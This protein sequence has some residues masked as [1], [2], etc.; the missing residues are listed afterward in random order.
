[1]K[2]LELYIHIPFCVQKCFYCDFLSMPV[3][4]TVRRHYVRRLIEETEYKS[5]QYKGYEITSVFFG[6]GTPS[7]L[8]ETQIAEIMEALQ[9]NFSIQK[10]AEITIECNPGTLARQKIITYKES[11]INRISMGLQSA[12][13][14]ELKMLGRIHTY[15]EFLHNYD[16]VRKGGI[17][18]VNVDLM[19][20]LPGQT[21]SDWERTLKEILKLR[22]EHISAYSLIIEEGTPFYQTYEEDEQRREEGEEP[23]YLPN[24]ETEREMY[25]LTGALLEEKGYMQYEIS[26]YAKKG[27]ECQHN[28][29]YWTRKNYLGLG[30]GSASLVENVRF[31]NTSDLQEYLAGDFEEREREVLER[32]EQMEE[33]M[34][35]GL[36]M[37]KGVSRGDFKKAFGVEIEAVYGE[38]IKKMVSQ[39]LLQQQAGRI[40]LTEEGISVSNYVMSEFLLKI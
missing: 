33:F 30:L 1:M 23:K 11:G 27:R 13:N 20:A 5:Q 16:L 29:G 6:G 34:F 3:D 7:I 14:R 31:S 2:E 38:V 35:L 12:N 15:E 8:M 22:P 9:Q 24:E 36:R 32:R 10:E 40:F 28:I 21:V 39:G 37:I 4:E 18:N 25:R 17:E 19:S 26:N